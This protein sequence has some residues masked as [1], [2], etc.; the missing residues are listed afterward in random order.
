MMSTSPALFELHLKRIQYYSTHP[1]LSFT[2][3]AHIRYLVAHRLDYQFCTDL[4]EFILKKA[5]VDNA[6]L[7]K[8]KEDPSASLL[9]ENEKAMLVFV[10]KAIKDPSSVTADDIQNLKDLGWEDRDM[11]D[12]LTQGVSMI[13]HSIM[14]QVFKMDQNCL[15]K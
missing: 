1:K 3:L 13:D 12:A 2:L 15:L 8:M 6:T 7:K 5:G 4:N 11:V 9:E 14:M 10:M